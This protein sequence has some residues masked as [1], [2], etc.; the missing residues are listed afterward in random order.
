MWNARSILA[1]HPLPYDE[2]TEACMG[3]LAETG[4]ALWVQIEE[5]QAARTPS[6]RYPGSA[7]CCALAQAERV[8]RLAAAAARRG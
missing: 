1:Q 2:Q 6:T 7:L 5:Q 8:S 3:V 4:Q